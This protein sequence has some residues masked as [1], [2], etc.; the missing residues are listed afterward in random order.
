MSGATETRPSP[1]T[2]IPPDP[3]PSLACKD[4]AAPEA[5]DGDAD[6]P[7]VSV[8]ADESEPQATSKSADRRAPTIR[9]APMPFFTLI[10]PFALGPAPAPG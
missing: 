5:P 10:S 9:V 3:V 6:E 1:L 7:P 4:A 2:L 8:D